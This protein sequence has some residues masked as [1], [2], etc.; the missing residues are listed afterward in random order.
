MRQSQEDHI[1]LM[2]GRLEGKFDA[3]LSVQGGMEGKMTE[4]EKRLQR[5]EHR[6]AYWAGGIGLG[7]CLIMGAVNYFNHHTLP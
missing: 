6:M 7:S 3:F 4:L 1:M 2:L 5:L